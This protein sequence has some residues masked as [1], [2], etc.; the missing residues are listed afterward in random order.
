MIYNPV[1]VLQKLEQN[2]DPEKNWDELWQ[3][4]YHQGDIGE[5]SYAALV[6]LVDIKAHQP[7]LDNRNLFDYAIVL[8]LARQE[9]H[10][11]SVPDWLKDAYAD[12]LERLYRIAMRVLEQTTA[13]AEIYS[14]MGVIALHKKQYILAKMLL[15]DEE[16]IIEYFENR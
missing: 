2:E 5:A 13:K 15:E 4:L 14:A 6:K 10:N 7:L 12:A 1:P 9:P 8:E 3:E 11:P 16:T